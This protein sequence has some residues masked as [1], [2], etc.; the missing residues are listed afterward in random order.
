MT[1]PDE[2][3]D[4]P[5]QTLATRSHEVIKRWAEE[6]NATPATVPGTEHGNRPGVLRFDFPGY[7]GQELQHISWDDWFTTFDERNLVF[8]FQEHMKNGNQ[9]NFFRFDSPEREEA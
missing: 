1:S 7:G 2:H 9:S 4:H 8:L 3:E 6:R 5:G